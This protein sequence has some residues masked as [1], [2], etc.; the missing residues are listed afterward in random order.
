MRKPNYTSRQIAGPYDL[1]REFAGKYFLYRIDD[2]NNIVLIQMLLTRNLYYF[3]DG[4]KTK[5]KIFNAVLPETIEVT[6]NAGV[7]KLK[8]LE[9]LPQWMHIPYLEALLENKKSP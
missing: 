4:I 8:P 7:R 2:E 5:L 3:G 1:V 6:F 9:E